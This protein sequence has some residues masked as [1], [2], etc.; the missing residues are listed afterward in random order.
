MKEKGGKQRNSGRER[1][2][3]TEGQ[4]QTVCSA[5]RGLGLP[6]NKA[7]TRTAA[8]W[9][10]RDPVPI[11]AQLRPEHGL[12]SSELQ[13]PCLEKGTELSLVGCFRVKGL[14]CVR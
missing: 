5:Y 11:L 8:L 7:P 2:E 9:R 10:Q 14:S 4:R 12:H 13:L 1:E 6:G 3:E